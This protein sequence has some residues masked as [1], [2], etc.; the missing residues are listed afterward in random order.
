MQIFI[1]EVIVYWASI[2]QPIYW[3]DAYWGRC[4]PIYWGDAYLFIGGDA[5]W[6]QFFQ[7]FIWGDVN[8]KKTFAFYQ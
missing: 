4:L 2:S 5:Y 8:F 6:K 3:G 7:L 1:G